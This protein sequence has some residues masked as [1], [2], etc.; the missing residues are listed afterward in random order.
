MI[1]KAE[2]LLVNPIPEAPGPRNAM[3]SISL[4]RRL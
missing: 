1:N 3:E 4:A 2:L